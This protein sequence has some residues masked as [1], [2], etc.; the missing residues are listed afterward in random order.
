LGGGVLY[1][2]FYYWNL[3][4]TSDC[5]LFDL[6]RICP[7]ICS[8]NSHNIALE[9]HAIKASSFNGMTC[10]LFQKLMPERVG[11]RDLGP[12]ID[13]DGNP[14]RQLSFKCNITSTLSSLALKVSTQEWP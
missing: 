9:A 12:R 11:I 7:I 3:K 5:C 10:T 1:V 8:Q 4:S 13:L 14:D 2:C 6:V